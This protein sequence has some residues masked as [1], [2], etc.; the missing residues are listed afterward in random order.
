MSIVE[1]WAFF[2]IAPRLT[3]LPGNS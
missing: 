3:T 2:T 1:L